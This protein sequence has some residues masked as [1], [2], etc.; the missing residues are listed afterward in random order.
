MRGPRAE[1]GDDDRELA[2][3]DQ[4]RAR[5][6]SAGYTGP[7]LP[8]RHPTRQQLSGPAEHRQDGRRCQ[9]GD[10]V[11]GDDGE[12]EEEE[13]RRGEQVAQWTH[14]GGGTRLN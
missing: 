1:C 6:N 9:H 7:D 5:S 4:R 11:A 13:E 8:G 14:H 2:A 10:E 3:R 12:G